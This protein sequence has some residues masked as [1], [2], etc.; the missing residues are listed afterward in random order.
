MSTTVDRPVETVLLRPSRPRF[1]WAH[2]ER[3]ALLGAWGVIVIAFSIALPDTYF[4]LGNLQNVFGS[5]SVLLIL[6]LGFLFPLT[7]GEFDLSGASTMSLSAMTVAVL[8]AQM[9]LPLG[10]SLLAAVAVG[11]TVGL[12]NGLLTV[13]FRIDSFIVTL[14]TSTLMIGLIQWMSNAS[15]VTGVDSAL[16]QATVGWRGVLGL[17]LAFVYGLA[18]TLIVLVVLTST[19]VGRRLLFVGMGRQ[20][21]ELSGLN[22]RRLRVGAFVGAGLTASVAG[23][24]YAGTLGGA[25]PSSGQSFLLPA[26]AA[27][28]LG[29]TA[30]LPGRFNAI[31]TFIAVYFLFSGVVGLQMLGAQNFVQQLFYGGALIVAVAVSQTIRRHAVRSAA[32]AAAKARTTTPA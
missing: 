1:A 22:V 11:I 20:V 21:A 4:T 8:N 24:V 13:A 2:T 23:I 3:Y 29:A 32:Q 7:A 10:V 28:Y 19:P 18:A 27:C 26:F 15:S 30:I 17:P 12:V 14:G 31:G 6:A 16:V 5:Q 25:D 9:G